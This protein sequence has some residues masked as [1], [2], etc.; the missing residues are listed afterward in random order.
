M[1]LCSHIDGIYFVRDE[2][3]NYK[4]LCIER[5]FSYV[6]GTCNTYPLLLDIL[7]TISIS[8]ACIN[9]FQYIGRKLE[10]FIIQTVNSRLAAED[11]TVNMIKKR[12]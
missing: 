6:V 12:Y 11:S 5:M 7:Q 4:A 1:N 9:R 10:Y 8:I 2:F 3:F